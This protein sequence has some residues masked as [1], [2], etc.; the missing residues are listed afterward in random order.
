[1][2]IEMKPLRRRSQLGLTLVELVMFIVIVSV[3]LAGVLTVLNITAKNSADPL[4]RKQMLAIAEAL[5]EEVQS[6]AFTYCDPTDANAATAASTAG[7]ATTPEGLG[8][9]VGET[10]TSNTNPFNNVN[11]YYVASTGYVLA[12]PIPDITNTFTSPAGYSAVINIVPEALGPVAA[13]V[14]DGTAASASLRIAITVSYG[15]NSL[16]VESYRT[17]YSPNF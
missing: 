13:L 3:A 1:M 4:I 7:C 5:L 10:R 15:S 16:V 12:S 11:D 9:D 6:K 8:P 14:G 2:C 17:R